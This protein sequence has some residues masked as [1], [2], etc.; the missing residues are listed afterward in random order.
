MTNGFTRYGVE[1]RSEVLRDGSPLGHGAVRP[2]GRGVEGVRMRFPD[3]VPR[4]HRR[5]RDAARTCRGRPR[6]HLGAVQGSGDPAVHGRARPVHARRRP[7]LRRDPRSGV[8]GRATPGASPSSR[9]GAPRRAASA[10][11]STSHH[12]GSGVADIGF[13]AHPD[14][15]GHGVVSRAVTL[16]RRLGIRRAGPSARSSG[17][18]TK[19]TP[20]PA[21]SRGRRDSRSRA[22]PARRSRNARPSVTA[23]PRPCSR[24]TPASRRL[25]GSTR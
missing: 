19:A 24:P 22:P 2:A 16:H 25:V 17:V 21:A 11:R 13:G 7:P 6:G 4:P 14:A 3:D 15:R 20:P 18:P 8:G 12:R 9:P 10:G 5:H 23:G 1:R